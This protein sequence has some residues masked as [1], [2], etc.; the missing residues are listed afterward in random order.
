[1]NL[2]MPC[3]WT[4]RAEVGIGAITIL[5]GVLLAVS[6]SNETKRMIGIIGIALGILTI[7]FPLYITKMCALADHPCNLLTKPFLVLLGI[8]SIAVS[9]WVIYDAQKEEIP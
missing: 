1:M 5:A 6:K 4:A 3:G 2:P 7:L 9:C 8:V